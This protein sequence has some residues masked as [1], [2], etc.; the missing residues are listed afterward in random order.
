MPDAKR[1]RVLFRLRQ[2]DRLP[3][4]DAAAGDRRRDRRAIVWR[5]MLLG[6]VFKAAGNQSPVMVPPKGRWMG[7]DMARFAR[8]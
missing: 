6:G 4:L 2:P 1:H 8:R 7:G 3:R 5:P